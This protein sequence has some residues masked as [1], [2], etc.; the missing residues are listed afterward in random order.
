MDNKNLVK[1]F[2]FAVGLL[3][4]I[5]LLLSIFYNTAFVSSCMLMTSLLMFGICYY[6]KDDRKNLMYLLFI[7]GVILIFASLI[8]TYLRLV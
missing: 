6:F 3:V 4:V 5:T 2:C 7:L 1:G 8:Y